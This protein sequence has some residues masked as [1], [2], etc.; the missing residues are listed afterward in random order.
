MRHS[1]HMMFGRVSAETLLNLKQYVLKYGSNDT[2]EYFTALHV[3][4]D[5]NTIVIQEAVPAFTEQDNVPFA[6][7]FRVQYEERARLENANALEA[8]LMRLKRSLVNA[9]HPGDFAELHYCLYVPLFDAEYWEQAVFII[10]ALNKDV[11]PKPHVDIV[12]FCADMADAFSGYDKNAYEKY[13]VIT[14]ETLKKVC[15]FKRKSETLQH[16]IALD[17]KQL[18]GVALNLNE[19]TLTTILGEFALLVVENYSGLFTGLIEDKDLCSFGLASMSIDQFYFVEYLL[20]R[21]YMNVLERE[22]VNETEV[23]YNKM[24]LL[25]QNILSKWVHLMSDFYQKEVKPRRQQKKDDHTVVV[26]IT[27]LLQ[28]KF[29]TLVEEVDEYILENNLD[30]PQKRA[31]LAVLLGLDDASLV[32]SIFNEKELI[33]Q[34]LERE[35]IQI[36][37]DSNNT[38]LERE[39]SKSSALL[40]LFIDRS[41]PEAPVYYPLDH[42]KNNR[43]SIKHCVSTIRELEKNEDKLKVQ[44]ANQIESEKC[45]IKNGVIT[46]KGQS[47]KLLPTVVD[48]P[49]QEQY[50]PHK[51]SSSSIDLRSNFTSIRNQGPIGSCLSHALVS[52]YEYF[53]RCNG[54][55]APDLSEMFLYYNARAIDG[56]VNEDVGSTL[57]ASMNSLAEY[58]I[59][60]E[61]EWPYV[62][63]NLSVKPSDAAYMDAQTRKVKTSLNVALDVDAIKSALEDG[64]PVAI[65]VN[66]FESFTTGVRGFIPVPSTEEKQSE[67]HGRHA[68]V[69]CGFSD[70]EKVFVVRNSWGLDFGDA[71][72]CYMPYA[73][74]ANPTLTN[75]AAIIKEI[76]TAENVDGPSK[77]IDN[78]IFT[79]KE[80]KRSHVNFD[81]T[82]AAMTLMATQA[83]LAEQKSLLEVLEDDDQKYSAYYAKLKQQLIDKNLQNRLKDATISRLDLEIQEKTANKEKIEYNKFEELNKYDKATF[84]KLIF[85]FIVFLA[86][87]I[88]GIIT[89]KIVHNID[90]KRI[91]VAKE[92]LERQQ[93]E[94]I[95]AQLKL[96]QNTD[97]E[98]NEKAALRA[99]IDKPDITIPTRNKKIIPVTLGIDLLILLGIG[100]IYLLRIKR[101]KEIEN[102]YN[103]RIEQV[104]IQIHKL[105]DEKDITAIKFFMSGFILTN[106]FDLNDK[107][108]ERYNVLKS[109]QNNLITWYNDLKD[110]DPNKDRGS[111]PTS[112]TLLSPEILD[113]FFEEQK[114]TITEGLKL[115]D[116]LEDFVLTE[117]GIVHLK[118]ALENSVIG[119]IIASLDDFSIYRYLAKLQDYPY[120]PKVKDSSLINTKLEELAT[121]SL[122]FLQMKATAGALN[123]QSTIFINV[124]ESE[125]NN[126]N[127]IYPISFSI[128][129]NTSSIENKGK[130]AVTNIQQL[131]LKDVLFM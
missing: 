19:K 3:T 80:E 35:A 116:F 84:R 47:F 127:A 86:I 26:E 67:E 95:E 37:I 70:E 97:L 48:P 21:T 62:P 72:Y 75:W 103:E 2:A 9:D 74:I 16:I 128:R 117:D 100:V 71:G 106:L 98:A 28:E 45:L 69:I 92:Q 126:W 49:L 15:D 110:E 102:E 8:Y 32:N 27:P 125:L 39:D 76:A 124:P 111:H 53:L 40:S 34:D 113:K 41:D 51:V 96:G 129:P 43:I 59:C 115:S 60:D 29:N 56:K 87:L 91:E 58:G 30:I 68:M 79:I 24:S 108:S 78:K 90:D 83:S 107:L 112:V 4:F 10:N 101:R 64:F 11:F 36:F 77:V 12:G 121:K 38:L 131:N 119:K 89:N 46:F 52:I 7:S 93:L 65:S 23:D 63:D 44:L 18:S 130:I 94:K 109:F 25:T 82:D 31:F 1:V 66:L 114:E 85:G 42:I 50:E 120:L 105:K 20:R 22:N 17:N 99:I 73:Y 81:H 118:K 6:D 55:S 54:L 57:Q 5:N 123:P 88:G 122:P 104:G 14:R 13:V 61:R 33:I